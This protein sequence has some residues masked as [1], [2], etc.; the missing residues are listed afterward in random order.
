[1]FFFSRGNVFFLSAPQHQRPSAI[2]ASHILF[3]KYLCYYPIILAKV[4]KQKRK[5][6]Y[7]PTC[8]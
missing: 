8:L 3:F 6:E 1:L 5:K 4:T 7:Y 2:S